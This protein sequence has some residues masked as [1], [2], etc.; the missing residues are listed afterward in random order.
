MDVKVKRRLSF[1]VLAAI[2]EIQQLQPLLCSIRSHCDGKKQNGTFIHM[3]CFFLL[4]L[5]STLLLELWL[6]GT[7]VLFLCPV[8]GLPLKITL[9]FID[10]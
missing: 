5:L 8:N 3:K 9:T 10:L 7:G 1:F 6:H 4:F 2:L